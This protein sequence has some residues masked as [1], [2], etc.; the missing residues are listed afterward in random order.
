M[1]TAE[2]FTQLDGCIV[3]GR[4][5]VLRRLGASR[6]SSTYLT[7]FENNP[8]KMATLKLVAA[9]EP[10]AEVRLAGWNS[11]AQ[12]SHPNVIGVIDCGR[13]EIDQGQFVYEVMDYADEVL[14]EILPGRPL[15]PDEA[16]QM[17]GP[18]LNALEY[19]HA[20]GFVHGRIKPSNILVVNDQ[21]KLSAD[22]IAL[23][24]GNRTEC[25]GMGVYEAPES[26]N[27]VITP[28]VDVWALGMTLVA[29]LTQRPAQWERSY[30]EEPIIPAEL[31][32]P[33]GQIAKAC[34]RV[35]SA[36]RCT[37]DGI[38]AI[39]DPE[40]VTVVAERSSEA[41]M[42][43]EPAKPA[44][45]LKAALIALATV[46]AVLGAALMI[47]KAEF[48]AAGVKGGEQQASATQS[49]A[50]PAPHT[51]AKKPS[52][53][54]REG[55]PKLENEGGVGTASGPPGVESSGVLLRVNPEVLPA[56]Q[57]SIR[58]E[59][60]VGVR[61]MVDAAGNVTNAELE[62]PS[63]SKYFNRVSVDAARQWKFARGTGG[64][65]RVQFQF[66]HDG[67]DLSATRE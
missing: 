49:V 1:N 56:A 67:T 42:P 33:F 45:S 4:F 47:R 64:A 29:A 23:A 34:L 22:S 63:A 20:H 24:G 10:D 28:A 2:G 44:G 41:T 65:W 32:E 3:N 62:S 13:C 60:N 16:R 31:A 61:V 39:L 50:T 12:L 57:Q 5:R 59:V 40:S 37:L 52:P 11:A 35:D 55:R 53:S 7:A 46:V 36:E 26:G 14:A 17:L 58:G 51:G 25:F 66:R 30:Q 54:A 38:R 43:R 27:G 19:L 15:T 48:P 8:P 9:T 21:L 6:A 18:M